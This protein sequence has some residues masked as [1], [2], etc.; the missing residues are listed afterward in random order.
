[1]KAFKFFF[2]SLSIITDFYD[3]ELNTGD[4]HVSGSEN[5]AP[6]GI[7]LDERSIEAMA[8]I[9]EPLMKK[10]RMKVSPLE[11]ALDPIAHLAHLQDKDSTYMSIADAESLEAEGSDEESNASSSSS[12]S[13][14]KTDEEPMETGEAEAST[15]HTEVEDSNKAPKDPLCTQQVGT[16]D[17]PLQEPENTDE[18]S[19]SDKLKDEMPVPAEA[20]SSNVNPQDLEKTTDSGSSAGPSSESPSGSS[21]NQ[22]SPDSVEDTS[23]Q[24]LTQKKESCR[25][26]CYNYWLNFVSCFFFSCLKI[27]YMNFVKSR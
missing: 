10:R 22:G 5:S 6:N 20:C 2:F 11:K 14:A 25:V 4:S 12:S 8:E 21:A 7:P 18:D 27:D 23:E 24:S 17:V 16:S 15:C 19:M 13:S 9:V 1:M 26:C 3:A